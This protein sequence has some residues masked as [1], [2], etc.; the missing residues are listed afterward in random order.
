[1][2]PRRLY[3]STTDRWIGGVAAG[4]AE[5]FDLDPVLVRVLWIVSAFFGGFTIL[6]YIVMLIVV[7][8]APDEWPQQSPWQPGGAPVGYNAYVPPAAPT[9]ASG[10]AP[11]DAQPGAPGE[12]GSAA[13][14]AANQ[15]PPAQGW[16][17][18]WAGRQDRWQ[19]RADRWQRRAER[20]G[21]GGLVFGVILIVVGGLLAWH[22]VDP[23]LDLGLAWPIAVII[24]GA[25]LVATSIGFGR[26]D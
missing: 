8:E 23:R 2:N 13:A 17:R 10:T 25:F 16:D 22:Q 7:P 20:R 18:G 14:P 11:A 6:V 12:P 21:S 26:N 24:F 9:G 19:R 3:R 5:Y 4:V 1:V 15:A